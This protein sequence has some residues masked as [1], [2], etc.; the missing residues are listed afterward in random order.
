LI[1]ELARDVDLGFDEVT[2]ITDHSFYMSKQGL[3]G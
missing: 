1:P 3:T 2:V